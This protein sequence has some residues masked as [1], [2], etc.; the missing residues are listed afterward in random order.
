M[1]KSIIYNEEARRALKAGVDTIA[2]AV[3]TTLWAKRKKYCTSK[4]FLDLKFVTK[5]GVTV[6]KEIE[7]KDPF[8][9][10]WSRNDKRSSK[11]G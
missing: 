10:V 9:N 11:S 3:K 8:K 6:A 2:N 7:D 5:D 1:A 4:K